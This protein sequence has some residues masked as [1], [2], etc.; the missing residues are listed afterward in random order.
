MAQR[1]F[2]EPHSLRLIGFFFTQAIG[3]IFFYL[4]RTTKCLTLARNF[5]GRWSSPGRFSY[6]FKLVLL[7]TLGICNGFATAC[8]TFLQ[9]FEVPFWNRGGINQRKSLIVLMALA[10]L[11]VIVSLLRIHHRSTNFP[12]LENSFNPYIEVQSLVQWP[13]FASFV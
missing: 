4:T 1:A 10:P 5:I 8:Y 6:F 13:Y 11:V 7:Y 3:F 12:S 9:Y 2:M